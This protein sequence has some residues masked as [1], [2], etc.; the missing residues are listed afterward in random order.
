MIWIWQRIVADYVQ[1]LLLVTSWWEMYSMGLIN[2]YYYQGVMKK[3]PGILTESHKEDVIFMNSE[4]SVFI[5]S[6]GSST[7]KTVRQGKLYVYVGK[8]TS[9]KT[10]CAVRARM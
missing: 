4:T 10:I 6:R 9:E 1:S 3:T 2:C 5:Y 7:V 8:R